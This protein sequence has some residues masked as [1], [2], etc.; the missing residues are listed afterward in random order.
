MVIEVVEGEQG[1]EEDEAAE[2]VGCGGE[3]TH[4]KQSNKNN[5]NTRHSRTGILAEK[6]MHCP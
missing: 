5:M 2:R 3:D 4:R 6:N 1:E